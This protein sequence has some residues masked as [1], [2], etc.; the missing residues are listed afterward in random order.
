VCLLTCCSVGNGQSV[1]KRIIW[2]SYTGAD[3]NQYRSP[4]WEK[5]LNGTVSMVGAEA[6][7]A[8]RREA[9][10]GVKFLVEVPGPLAG[11]WVRAFED[12]KAGF[13]KSA[14]G[15]VLLAAR[16]PNPKRETFKAGSVVRFTWSVQ[17]KDESGT[18]IWIRYGPDEFKAENVAAK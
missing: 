4:R 18:E 2:K 11:S 7:F 16:D 6:R 13:G 12:D 17:L 1:G 3:G 8:P 5:N 10:T 14:A 9:V 15:N